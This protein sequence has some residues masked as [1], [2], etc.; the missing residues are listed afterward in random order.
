[1]TTARCA[2]CGAQLDAHQ[3]SVRYQLPDVLFA[4]PDA[5]KEALWLA[6]SVAAD[7][8]AYGT[9][10]FVRV[11]IPIHLDDDDSVTF[12]AWLELT[13]DDFERVLRTWTTDRYGGLEIEGRLANALP[14]WGSQ[15]LG[16]HCRAAVLVESQIP[17][18]VSS[19]DPVLLGILKGRHGATEVR[20][21]L[22][23]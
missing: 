8:A 6:P 1:M 13:Y 5:D 17:Y 12:G 7:L 14:P 23:E 11:L 20:S 3:R 22:P 2:Y 9:R 18:V 16:R 10:G 19:S 15:L 4:L 21:A